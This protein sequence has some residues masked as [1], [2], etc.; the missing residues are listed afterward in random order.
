MLLGCSA[1][2]GFGDHV[3]EAAFEFLT[4]FGF[5]LR[6][7]RSEGLVCGI[8]ARNEPRVAVGGYRIRLWRGLS[9]RRLLL[10]GSRRWT[11]RWGLLLLVGGR[12]HRLVSGGGP[13]GTWLVGRWLCFRWW[14]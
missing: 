5:R 6:K 9:G 11:R 14:S 13:I 7:G 2:G 10:R 4:E 1:P 3:A 12:W 8:L